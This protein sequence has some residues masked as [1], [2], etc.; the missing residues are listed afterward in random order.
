MCCVVCGVFA[1]CLLCVALFGLVLLRLG[2]VFGIRVCCFVLWFV[3]CVF[4]C[5]CVF[6]V[7]RV[8]FRVCFRFGV[9]V[10]VVGLVWCGVLVGLVL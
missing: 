3:L 10:V 2:F 7:V 8:L 5:V 9:A 1:L 4:V 6:D